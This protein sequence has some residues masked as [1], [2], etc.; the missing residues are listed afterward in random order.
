MNS[1]H[2]QYAISDDDFIYLLSTFVEEPIRWLERN[3]WSSLTLL[4]QEA[5]F[6]CWD[7]VGGRMP[8]RNVPTTLQELMAWNQR[9]KV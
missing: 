5:M 3:G 4:E 7:H 1:I 2:G 6:R 8:I 9:F